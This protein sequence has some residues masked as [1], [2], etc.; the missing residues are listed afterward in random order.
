MKHIGAFMNANMNTQNAELEYAKSVILQEINGLQIFSDHIDGN[1]ISALDLILSKSGCVVVSGMGKPGHVG[2]KISATLASTGTRSFFLHPAE[3]NHG[4]LGAISKN[5]VLLMLSLSGNT[6]ELLPTL[7]YASR[8]KIDVIAITANEDSKLSKAAT[9]KIIIPKIPEACPH[10]LAPTTSTTI[11]MAIGDAIA[12]CLLKR[13]EF[14]REHFKE[15]HPGG[16]LGTQLLM[17]KDLMHQD[18]PVAKQNDQMGNVLI[19]MTAK[20]FGC[21]CVIDDSGKVVGIITDGDLRRH[22]MDNF[23]YMK[24]HEI[25]SKNPKSIQKETFACDAIKIMN[26]YKITSLFVVENGFPCGIIHIHD[27]LRAGLG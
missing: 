25:M 15:L 3:A 21:A 11:M 24:A 2:K 4:D 26:R 1:F 23:L 12:L 27:C 20:S 14:K 19:E 7:S 18:I 16:A 6:S 17:V 9:C 10:N 13:K 8:Y 5:D 22:V